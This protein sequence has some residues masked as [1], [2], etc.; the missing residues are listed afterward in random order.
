[1]DTGRI[2]PQILYFFFFCFLFARSFL[3]YSFDSLHASF[4]KNTGWTIGWSVDSFL[5]LQDLL[6]SPL[7][8]SLEW[9]DVS[10]VVLPS[11][12]RPPSG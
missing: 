9:S 2:K 5:A 11:A 10:R 3:L 1:M 7:G 8:V 12:S 4:L 6:L